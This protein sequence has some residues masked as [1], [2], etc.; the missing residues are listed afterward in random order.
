MTKFG[1]GASA[2]AALLAGLALA[3]APQAALAR[4]D[5]GQTAAT[6]LT[7]AQRYMEAENCE[8]ALGQ[9]SPI[10]ASKDFPALEEPVRFPFLLIS[11]LCEARTNRIEPALVHARAAT[12]ITGAPEIAWTLRFGIELDGGKPED[13]VAT[14]EAMQQRLPEGIDGVDTEWLFALSRK[15]LEDK[16]NPAYR[17]LLALL[18]APEFARGKEDMAFDWMRRS[19]ARLLLSSGDR[20]AAAAQIAAIRSADALREITLDPA[21]RDMLPASFDLRAAYERQIAAL[22]SR[23]VTRP[24]LLELPIAIAASRRTLGQAEKALA[25]LEAARPEGVLSKQFSD[26]DKQLNWWWDGMARTYEQLGRYDEAA[27]AYRKAIEGGERGAGNFSQTINLAY[28]HSRFGHDDAALATL[29]TVE[30]KTDSMAS[31]Y[32]VMELRLARG[33]AAQALGKTDLAQADLAYAE[34]HAADH[35]EAVTDLQICT[36]RIDAAAASMIARLDD[37]D[38]RINALT[39]LSDYDPLPANLPPSP[40]A[41]GLETLKHRPDVQAAIARAGGTRKFNIFPATL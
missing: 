9:V 14:L 26:H 28:L 23:S 17:R 32:G 35:P 40:F 10:V 31:P 24:G 20:P 1:R 15:F 8:G 37:P 21:L 12:A 34:A 3:L 19:Y 41:A 29:A 16:D 39:Q 36:G 22:E 4:K 7:Q 13:A 30:G 11:T 27:A 6:A 2:R 18:T 5:I 38:R 33:C 25:T